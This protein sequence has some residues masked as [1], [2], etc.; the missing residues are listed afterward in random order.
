MTSTGYT[1]D[2]PRTGNWPILSKASGNQ[3]LYGVQG[4]GTV[5]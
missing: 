2:R 3:R 4:L 1:A 5:A